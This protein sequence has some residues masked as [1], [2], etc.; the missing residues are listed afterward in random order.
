MVCVQAQ[1]TKAMNSCGMLLLHTREAGLNLIKEME[2]KGER[3]APGT[4]RVL[5]PVV[6]PHDYTSIVDRVVRSMMPTVTNF[7]EVVG[8][9]LQDRWW[10]WAVMHPKLDESRIHP[11]RRMFPL[12]HHCPVLCA[13][14]QG[15]IGL[16]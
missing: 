11:S 5:E 8:E 1:W 7:K 6:N 10:N 14:S 12:M 15:G 2:A 16:R 9:I 4:F 13:P 3:L